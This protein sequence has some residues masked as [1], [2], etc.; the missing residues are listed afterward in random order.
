MSL[1]KIVGV[2]ETKEV[3][4][5]RIS[6]YHIVHIGKVVIDILACIFSNFGF[7]LDG[8]IWKHTD[9]LETI[10]ISVLLNI[11]FLKMLYSIF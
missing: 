10:I 5:V 1:T 7:S 9:I 8:Y 4:K 2:K 11:L 3:L 6:L